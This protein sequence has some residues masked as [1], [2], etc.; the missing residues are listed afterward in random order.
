MNSET[1]YRDCA[2][3]HENAFVN[4]RTLHC[5]AN[6]CRV[7]ADWG[8]P[9]RN[10]TTQQRPWRSHQWLQKPV[11]IF[12]GPQNHVS[13]TVN[14]EISVTQLTTDL[15][16]FNW[17]MLWYSFQCDYISFSRPYIIIISGFR[18]NYRQ[19][20]VLYAYSRDTKVSPTNLSR[21]R[22]STFMAL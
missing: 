19:P 5:T 22:N 17:E 2:D 13:Q 14:R 21:L 10:G 9:L 16:L 18:F 7:V 4:S 20:A 6:H 3:L 12:Y 8:W 11:I 1:R 15:C